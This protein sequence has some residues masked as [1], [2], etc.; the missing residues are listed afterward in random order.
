MLENLWLDAGAVIGLMHI[1]GP[2]ALR[3]TYRF[4]AKCAPV[5]V[6]AEDLPEGVAARII[7]R[8]AQIESLGF[9]LAGC[10]YLGELA[11]HTKSYVAYFRNP[12][13]NDFANV[14]VN[15]TPRGA[16]SYFEFSTRFS[17]GPALETNTNPTLPLA[18]ANPNVRVFR[19]ADISEPGDLLV[20]HR[21]LIE[22]YAAGLWPTGEPKGEEIKRLVRVI[23]NYGPRHTKIGH[24]EPA[25]DGKC[26]RL[27]WKGAFL[28]AWR[29]L[30][31]ASLIHR[32]LERQAMRAEL[33]S[34]QAGGVTELQK[35]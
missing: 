33:R 27:T 24:M 29:G 2:V 7:P 32:T 12:T 15:V 3:S 16:G 31:P 9:S 34:L 5:K 8:L 1:A 10:Y 18:P 22:K 13:T 26:Y 14:T 4:A 6:A 28:M 19:F 21:Q 20:V 25:G 23:E 17:N 30:L 11:I 35:A